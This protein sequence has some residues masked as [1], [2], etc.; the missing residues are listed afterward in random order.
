MDIVLELINSAGKGF[1][2]FAW[3][4]LWQVSM[5]MAILLAADCL[6]RRKVRAVFRYWLWMLVIVKLFLPTSLSS[7]VSIGQFMIVPAGLV[8]IAGHGK[9]QAGNISGIQLSSDAT[10]ESQLNASFRQSSL[11]C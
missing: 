5:L 9:P 7:P 11:L 6:L 1:V 2:E 4:M 3:P 10:A 8:K